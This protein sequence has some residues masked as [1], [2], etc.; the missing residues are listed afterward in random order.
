MLKAIKSVYLWFDS[1]GDLPNLQNGS[2]IDWLRCSPFFLLHVLCLGVFFVKFEWSLLLVLLVTYVARVFALTA[3]YHRF[4]SHRAF[5]TSRV[6]Q[7]IFAFIGTTATQRGPLWWA[8]HH[9][10]HHKHTDKALDRHSPHVHS[11]LWSHCGW[12]LAAENFKTDLTNIKDLY[13]YPELRFLDRYDVVPPIMLSAL[14]YW[15][16]G[17]PYVVWGY[18]LSTVLIYHVT[19]AVNSIG[20][21]VGTQSFNTPDHSKNN[22]LLAIFAFGEG[23]HNNH[24]HCPSSARQ[25]RTVWQLD[26]S[27]LILKIMEKC[28]LVWDLREFDAHPASESL[29]SH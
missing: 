18:F 25:G 10:H 15:F 1:S 16:G 13:K 17:W 22:W 2:K 19:F 7:F 8:A 14:L 26:I 5:K 20:H 9:R 4:F 28:K 12:F 23:W 24:H 27:Y 11:F 6:V 3:F 21:T 29:P